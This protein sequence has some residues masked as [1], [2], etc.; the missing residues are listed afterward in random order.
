M[1]SK[2]E[3]KNEFWKKAAKPCDNYGARL[4]PRE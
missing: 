1:K 3:G 2:P 4:P